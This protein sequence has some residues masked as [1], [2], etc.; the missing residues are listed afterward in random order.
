MT[1]I[2]KRMCS[3]L[4]EYYRHRFCI[5]L[6]IFKRSQVFSYLLLTAKLFWFLQLLMNSEII[7]K[8]QHIDQ[9][10]HNIY[11]IT[12]LTSEYFLSIS[13]LLPLIFNLVIL[14]LLLVNIISFLSDFQGNSL[15]F[16]LSFLAQS[17]N[18]VFFVPLM[19]LSSPSS[20]SFILEI[21]S[22]AI[23]F[24]ISNLFLF[25]KYIKL[26]ICVLFYS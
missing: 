25:F 9:N 12:I 20:S 7:S 18:Y 13:V 22:I 23:S 19:I 3:K 11:Q 17:Y 15:R 8:I 24:M 2:Q 5:D 16:L 1:S 14:S 6:H 4:L 26:L 21:I 10:L